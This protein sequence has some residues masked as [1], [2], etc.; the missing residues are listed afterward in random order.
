MEPNFN[1]PVL[2]MVAH[3]DD[4]VI[5][6]GGTLLKYGKGWDICSATFRSHEPE[7]EE[8]F[9]RVC[10]EVGASPITLR[11]SHR[12]VE[13]KY[14]VFDR[15]A[16]VRQI[17]LIKLTEDLIRKAARNKLDIEKYHTIIT[18]G[19]NGDINGH[20]Q[21]KQLALI[22][23]NLCYPNLHNWMYRFSWNKKTEY[24]I[25]MTEEEYEAKWKLIKM[26]KPQER[27]FIPRFE[28]FERY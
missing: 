27:R 25:E 12:I 28:C 26:Y 5:H 2:L 4:E 11:I 1:P 10:K 21:H 14:T 22:M 23:S 9:K 6:A 24:K 19:F 3:W 13:A 8:I 20:E 18:H 17:P 16:Y 7:H 15:K